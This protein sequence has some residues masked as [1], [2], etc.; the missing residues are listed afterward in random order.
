MG[1]VLQN[2]PG[3]LSMKMADGTARSFR[4]R[5]T[6][7]DIGVMTQIFKNKDYS[8]AGLA[9]GAELNAS[10]DN[11]SSTGKSPIIVDLGANIGASVIWFLNRFPGAHVVAF[12]PDPGN[13]ELLQVN[14][15]G[16][17]VDIRK[18]A[19]GRQDGAVAIDDPGTG[20]WGYRTRPDPEGTCEMVSLN[21]IVQEKQ[22]AGHTP[23]LLKIDIEGAEADLFD[24]PCGWVDEWPIIVIEL[25]DW[26]L[27]GQGTSRNFL[28]C[29][30]HRD[31]DFVSIGENIFSI[32]NHPTS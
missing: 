26:L 24:G 21:R 1:V 15:D 6:P 31:R 2:K 16:L 13:F 32:R 23:F 4:H 8:L 12:E 28:R 27:P 22:Q 18:A 5:G 11:L 10:F 9:R 20:E 14:T 3:A 30:G 7:A 25:H 19:I 29:I 17:N